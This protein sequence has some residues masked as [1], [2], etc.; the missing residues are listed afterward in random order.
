MAGMWPAVVRPPRPSA[1]TA[2][3]AVIAA[4]IAGPA[5]ASPGQRPDAEASALSALYAGQAGPLWVD[6][7]NRPTADARAA[8]ALLAQAPAD[9]LDAADYQVGV[10]SA[11]AD[12]LARP[13]AAPGEEAGRFD[14]ALSAALLRYCRDLHLGRV[15]PRALGVR[16]V[17]DVEHHDFAGLVRQALATHTL[18]AVA[19]ELT[20]ALGQYRAL[21]QVLT[22]YRAMAAAGDE[23]L[24]LPERALSPGQPFAGTAALRRRLISLGDLPADAPAA[25]NLSDEPLTTGVRRFQVRHGLEPDGVIGRATRAA[26]AVPARVRVRQIELAL[27]RLRWLPDL[28]DERLVALNIPMFRLWAADGL[29]GVPPALSMRAIVGRALRTETP[30]FTAEMQSVIFRPYWNVPRSILLAEILPPLERDPSRLQRPTDFEMVRGDA[31][32]ATVI[33]PSVASL[34]ELRA[35]TLR[36]RQR[37]GPNNALGL[38]K[39][40]FPNTADVYMHGT[41]AMALFERD[42]RDFSHG[43]VRV[44]DPAALAEWV[45]REEPGWDRR[46]IEAAMAAAAPA[47][48][49]LTRPIRVVLF[50]TTAVVVPDD[51]AVHFA[52]DIYGHDARLERA[53]AARR[54]RS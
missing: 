36:L 8:L 37:P 16:L 45:L 29:A 32:T 42:R 40:M 2:A 47:R 28:G 41:P 27:E 15:D 53:L 24:S 4:L 17:V 23:P 51:G 3:I 34:A 1:A 31:D 5:P 21:R 11:M 19:V 6:A 18:P 44:Q 12:A 7:A 54:D 9:G 43:C 26:L 13:G 33:A 49:E 30:V 38:V 35:G 25:T 46:R 39:F 20:P 22:G 14:R 10:L 52:A 50:Y 48:V